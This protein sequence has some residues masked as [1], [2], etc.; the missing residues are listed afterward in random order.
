MGK[1]RGQ[2]VMLTRDKVHE[3]REEQVSEPADELRKELGWEPL[4]QFPEGA[5][6]SVAWYRSAG[7]L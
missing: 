7:L 5:K 1:V 3:L 6:H 4:V 2:A